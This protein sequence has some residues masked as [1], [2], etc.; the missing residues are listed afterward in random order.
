[1][2]QTQHLFAVLDKVVDNVFVLDISRLRICASWYDSEFDL[3]Q[4]L[5]LDARSLAY[6]F[7]GL[8]ELFASFQNEFE[9]DAMRLLSFLVEVEA[10]NEP[11]IFGCIELFLRRL[12]CVQRHEIAYARYVEVLD[13][14]LTDLT[15]M[16][17][18][19]TDV[20]RSCFI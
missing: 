11:I 17:L 6:P 20:A 10:V 7:S 3:L 14:L 12:F 15:T 2:I 9:W 13:Q 18:E 5:S 19:D 16:C 4:Q 8:F 1:M